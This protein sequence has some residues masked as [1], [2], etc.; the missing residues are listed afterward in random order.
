[1]CELPEDER[2][3]RVGIENAEPVDCEAI[4]IFQLGKEG[5]SDQLASH[6]PWWIGAFA[7]LFN[8]VN[9]IL[10]VDSNKVEKKPTRATKWASK[11]SLRLFSSLLN[12]L[13][14]I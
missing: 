6:L 13:F 5:I 14:G 7:R 12:C 4:C 8:T 2:V 3:A 9:I 11:T 10:V 1:V